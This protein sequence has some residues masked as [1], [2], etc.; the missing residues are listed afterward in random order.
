MSNQQLVKFRFNMGQLFFKHPV[1]EKYQP[2][3]LGFV[4]SWLTFTTE[5]KQMVVVFW[6]VV[7]YE[8]GAIAFFFS[9]AA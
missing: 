4:C 2:L 8:I 5:K 3:N 6:L 1:L 7:L 9:I